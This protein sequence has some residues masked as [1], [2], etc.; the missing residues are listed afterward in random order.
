MVFVTPSTRRWIVTGAAVAAVAEAPLIA[1]A[2]RSEPRMR[3][4]MWP[5]FL[6]GR[7]ADRG[8]VSWLGAPRRAFPECRRHPSGLSDESAP[9]HSGGTAPASHR[10][11][12]DHR[13]MNRHSIPAATIADRRAAIV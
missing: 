11:S 8:Q 7:W 2:I 12:L 6:E 5:P 3:L 9:V 4:V 10:T 13:P 1:R